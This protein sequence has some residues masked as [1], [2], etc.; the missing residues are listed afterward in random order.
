MDPAEFLRETF[1]LPGSATKKK[2]KLREEQG[3]NALPALNTKFDMAQQSPSANQSHLLGALWDGISPQRCPTPEIGQTVALFSHLSGMTA[4]S[5]L[6]VLSDLSAAC[7][8]TMGSMG[9]GMSSLLMAASGTGKSAFLHGPLQRMGEMIFDLRWGAV[10]AIA[11]HELGV[12]GHGALFGGGQLYA[13][14]APPGRTIRQEIFRDRA[15]AFDRRLNSVSGQMQALLWIGSGPSGVPKAARRP[16]AIWNKCSIGVP[17][18]QDTNLRCIEK[19]LLPGESFAG[20]CI[21]DEDAAYVLKGLK[22]TLDTYSGSKL[23]AQLIADVQLKSSCEPIHRNHRL[24]AAQK[25]LAS[26]KKKAPPSQQ[27]LETQQLPTLVK[28]STSVLMQTQRATNLTN[29]A[30][31]SAS[32]LAVQQQRMLFRRVLQKAELSA[33]EPAFGESQ[34]MLQRVI[35]TMACTS[36]AFSG[37]HLSEEWALAVKGIV[38]AAGRRCKLHAQAE[39]YTGPAPQ[40]VEG[41]ALEIVEHLVFLHSVCDMMVDYERRDELEHL[42]SLFMSAQRPALQLVQV[43]LGESLP[44]TTLPGTELRLFAPAWEDKIG[45]SI[46]KAAVNMALCELWCFVA[47]QPNQIGSGT[48]PVSSLPRPE[49]QPAWIQCCVEHVDM[50]MHGFLNDDGCPLVFRL[51]STMERMRGGSRRRPDAGAAAAVRSVGESCSKSVASGLI[52][53]DGALQLKQ[54]EENVLYGIQVLQYLNKRG[55]PIVPKN[56]FLNGTRRAPDSLLSICSAIGM[57]PQSDTGKVMLCGLQS[58]SGKTVDSPLKHPFSA[59]RRA[60]ISRCME[61]HNMIAEVKFSGN[62]KLRVMLP[63]SKWDRSAQRVLQDMADDEQRK[64]MECCAWDP[65]LLD[66]IQSKDDLFACM[67]ALGCFQRRAEPTAVQ[68]PGAGVQPAAPSAAG[69]GGGAAHKTAGAAS[70]STQDS[71]EFQQNALASAQRLDAPR[72]TEQDKADDSDAAM[73]WQQAYLNFVQDHVTISVADYMEL[74]VLYS[75][76]PEMLNVHGQKLI[77]AA[78]Q[79]LL[80]ECLQRVVDH[81][82]SKADIMNLRLQHTLAL[83]NFWQYGKGFSKGELSRRLLS[84]AASCQSAAA[85]L[86]PD[87]DLT[88]DSESPVDPSSVMAAQGS[89]S[90]KELRVSTPRKTPGL[91]AASTADPRALGP[92]KAEKDASTPGSGTRDVRGRS[93]GGDAAASRPSCRETPSSSAPSSRSAPTLPPLHQLLNRLNMPTKEVVQ[94]NSD[95]NQ[96]GKTGKAL[97]EAASSSSPCAAEGKGGSTSRRGTKRWRQ[98]DGDHYDKDLNQD[99]QI[100]AKGTSKKLFKHS[101]ASAAG[102]TTNGQEAFA[103]MSHISSKRSRVAEPTQ[104]TPSVGWFERMRQWVF[105]FSGTTGQ[106]C[107]EDGTQ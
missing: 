39:G 73:Q 13:V 105:S 54:A 22:T 47:M 20:S 37:T 55:A 38:K 29:S 23:N 93:T 43:T 103:E 82:Y 40:A 51:R 61:A 10:N 18:E 25:A 58:L 15:P 52:K 49:F 27:Q 3:D 86:G 17:H 4:G 89:I 84:S 59:D 19:N 33:T 77:E 42:E 71:S 44:H 67:D 1:S 36:F 53:N 63:S 48:G 60:E 14:H 102:T 68:P 79:A 66:S 62:S 5:S 81:M 11:C 107:H 57:D 56:C 7:I 80:T 101:D 64:D 35:T 90:F 104:P 88:S 78:S 83:C 85:T 2:R 9:G 65:T 31:D 34:A 30:N 50:D 32:L 98:D 100:V 76:L 28:R 91:A 92:D 21:S 12:A 106:V 45:T 6:Q 97:V 26:L 95:L 74:F 99:T 24:V 75:A 46:C 41:R 96:G 72:D 69:T 8:G 94:P 87:V 16:S 70:T